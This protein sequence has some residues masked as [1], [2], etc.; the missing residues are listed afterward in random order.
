VKGTLDG[1][2]R[3]AG[4]RLHAADHFLDDVPPAHLRRRG[5]LGDVSAH[6]VVGIAIFLDAAAARGGRQ[7]RR[8]GRAREVV[9]GLVLTLDD[10]VD[11]VVAVPVGPDPADD[12][13]RPVRPRNPPA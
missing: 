4:C 7:R 8:A 1:A 3:L 6:L 9:V 2:A 5:T 10:L 13:S 12:S 11:Q